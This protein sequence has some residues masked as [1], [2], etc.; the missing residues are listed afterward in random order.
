M[1]HKHF[2][3]LA[4]M[5][6]GATLLSAK[7]ANAWTKVGN[8]GDVVVCT[9]PDGDQTVELL[10][11]F[12]A[13]EIYGKKLDLP[14]TRLNPTELALKLVERLETLAPARKQMFETYIKNFDEEAIFVNYELQDIPDHGFIKVPANCAIRQLVVNACSNA[15][16]SF[17]DK[18]F[19]QYNPERGW[20]LNAKKINSWHEVCPGRY[21][22]NKAL[23]DLLPRDE[24]ALVK[25]HEAF[26]RDFR[27]MGDLDFEFDGPYH[28]V[29]YFNE[30]LFTSGFK[31]YDFAKF[32]K[33]YS[34]QGRLG[35]VEE[36][37]DGRL[38]LDER[39]MGQA[40]AVTVVPQ[41]KIDIAA[42]AVSGGSGTQLKLTSSEMIFGEM[43]PTRTMSVSLK[44]DS[45]VVRRGR[46]EYGI[47]DLRFSGNLVLSL[48]SNGTWKDPLGLEKVLSGE[49]PRGQFFET[50][51]SLVPECDFDPA[52]GGRTG[53]V[54]ADISRLSEEEIELGRLDGLM[55]E[56]WLQVEYAPL[57]SF[58]VK[59]AILDVEV[60]A[61]ER[62]TERR[63]ILESTICAKKPKQANFISFKAT[64]RVF[65]KGRWRA[66]TNKYVQ[67]DLVSMKVE[68]LF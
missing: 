44:T 8:G 6:L 56:R 30:M 65:F 28:P 7:N 2:A 52:T 9:D 57:Y 21:Q 68:S 35:N 49:F 62:I 33:L 31:T 47:S 54:S 32:Q 15:S 61:N 50:G 16:D 67:V 66:I 17:F 59:N 29:R 11:V 14:R 46:P 27:H 26:M 51:F 24:Q 38:I 25:T 41:L 18:G 42:M 63:P 39:N 43:S 23:W 34:A 53:V 22:I 36:L 12:E 60:T 55:D 20:L 13:R 37:K 5:L 1:K 48:A 19:D 10:D 58:K 40:V 3:A 45:E 4:A 64:G